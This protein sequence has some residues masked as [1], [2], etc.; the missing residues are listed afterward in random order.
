MATTQTSVER[1]KEIKFKI[2]HELKGTKDK[3]EAFNN[4]R[5]HVYYF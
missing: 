4:S 1:I 5:K 2:L 3:V